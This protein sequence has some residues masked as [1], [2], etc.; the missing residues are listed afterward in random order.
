MGLRIRL[1]TEATGETLC[2][3][4]KSNPGRPVVQSVVKQ[5]SDWATAAPTTDIH[6]RVLHNMWE[7]IQYKFPYFKYKHRIQTNCSVAAIN[8]RTKPVILFT[9]NFQHEVRRLIPLSPIQTRLPNLWQLHTHIPKASSVN[10]YRYCHESSL[11]SV[12]NKNKQT[13]QLSVL[14]GTEIFIY[15]TDRLLN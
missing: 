2:L 8:L 9:C 11:F 7:H 4:R 1:D 13:Y 14:M 6:I 12:N 3:C 15:V 10:Y 5:D